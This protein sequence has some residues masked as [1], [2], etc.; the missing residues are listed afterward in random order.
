M[1]ASILSNATQSPI[2]NGILNSFSL[3]N[4]HGLKPNTVP[5]KVPYIADLLAEKNQLFMAVTETWLSNHKD[6]ELQIDGYKLFRADRKRVK[7][8][9]RGRFSGGVGCYVRLDLACTMETVIN[10]SNGVVELLCLYSKVH[11]MYIAVVYRQPD[12]RVGNHRSTETE[13]LPIMDK[14]SESLSSLPNPT[15][16]IF[17]CGDFNLPHATWSDETISTSGSTSEK[18]MIE[19]VKKL[20]TD[21][22]LEQ[23]VTSPT[24]VDGG[25]LDLVFCNN[26]AVI[27]SYV[28]LHPLRST[29]DHFVLEVSTQLLCEP[30]ANEHERPPLIA[31]L[32]N[33]N[34]HSNDINWEEMSTTITNM[35]NAEDFS[36]LSPN[37]HLERL[38]K[39]LIDVAYKFVPAKKSAKQGNTKIPRHRR[40]LMRKRRKLFDKLNQ[41]TSEPK[42]ASLRSKLVKIE[43]LLQKSHSDARS[44]KEQLAVKAIKTNSKF[45]FSYA[46]QFSS[47]KSTIGPLLN[48]RNEYTASSSKMANL[49]ST[50]YSSVFSKPYA[51]SPYYSIQESEDDVTITNIEFSEQDIIDAIDELKNTSASGPDG[52]AAIFLKKCKDSLARPLFQLWRK[53][54]DQGIT[55]CKLKEAHIIP[56]HK[57][58]HQ[59]LPANYRPVALTSHVIKVFEKVVR[60]YIVQFLEDNNK[61]NDSQHGF[62]IGRSCVSELL[63]HYDR[64]VDILSRGSNVDTIYLDFAK[65]FDKVDHGIVLKKLS[66]LGIRGQLLE[67]IKSFLSSR[68]QMVLVNGVLSEPAPVTSGVPQGS[69]IGPLLFLILIGDIDQNV[70]QSFLSSFADDTRLLREVNGVQ[71]ASALQRDLETVYQW[72][73]DNNAS[74]NNKKFEVLRHGNDETL[75]LSTNYTAPDGTIITEKSNLRDL[76]VTMS[77]DGTFKQHITNVCQSARNMCSWILRTFESRSPELMLTLWKSMVIPILD[78]CSQLWSPSKIGDIQQIEELQKAFTRKIRSSKRDDYWQRLQTFHLYSLQRRRERYRIIYVWKT[79][80]G[81]VPNLPGRSKIVERTSLRNGRVCCIPAVAAVANN[82]LARLREGSFCVNGPLLFNALPSN[83]RNMTGVGHI[84]FKRELDTFLGTV[85]DEPLL[86]GYTAQRK[87]ESNSLLHMIPLCKAN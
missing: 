76:G 62:R 82:R 67:W 51:D 36:H 61:F 35:V 79:L 17:F 58:G 78:Y 44:R 49:L 33:L 47:T 8:T 4:V 34:F 5:S 65:A 87:A 21:H 70:A 1:D 37:D 31:V 57:G 46:K 83:L 38:M 18:I 56:I 24:H 27:H 16:N 85:A 19:K 6:G 32:D 55:P 13:F 60:N 54:L 29:S 23:F 7:R 22:F 69:V 9:S 2:S 15:P 45:F 20:Q 72:A 30:D 71:D 3:F 10:C 26:A 81:I 64:I 39:I 14:L 41:E 42:R 66:L 12:D 75:K 52:L 59:G 40:I 84:D 86:R 11:N 68:S 74:F 77:A 50:Q 48:E 53:C 80:E 73:I 28:T 43:L 25:M 63:T